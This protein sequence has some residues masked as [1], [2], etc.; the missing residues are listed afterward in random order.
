MRTSTS[1]F[2]VLFQHKFTGSLNKH[3]RLIPTWI[4]AELSVWT[5]THD[6]NETIFNW[7]GGILVTRHGC[8]VNITEKLQIIRRKFEHVSLRAFV[9]NSI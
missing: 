6:A 1:T 2:R 7:S 9:L 5:L 8:T 4:F 3:S